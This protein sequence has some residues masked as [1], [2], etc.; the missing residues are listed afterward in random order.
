MDDEMAFRAFVAEAAIGLRRALVAG[1]G[2]DVGQEALSEAL[3]YGWEHWDRVRS[4][5]NPAGYLYRVGYRWGLRARRHRPGVMFPPPSTN[6]G[7][8][9]EP[10]L[11]AALASLSERQRVAVVM[12]EA[13]GWT[14]REVA[15]L[16]SISGGAVETHV[17]RGLRRLRAHLEADRDSEPR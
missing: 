7:I 15:Q 8:W 3:A 1:L 4:M 6:E 12:V 2:P 11:P 10:E 16:M 5:D 9:V 13:Y 17:R 14:Y